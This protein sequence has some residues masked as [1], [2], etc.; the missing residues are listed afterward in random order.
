MKSPGAMG[1]R[2]LMRHSSSWHNSS[3]SSHLWEQAPL[4][5]FLTCIIFWLVVPNP[6]RGI[7]FPNKEKVVALPR[8]RFFVAAP[9]NSEQC[10]HRHR[11]RKIRRW[12]STPATG[13]CLE[14]PEIM[15]THRSSP[16][17]WPTLW[18]MWHQPTN[19][20]CIGSVRQTFVPS[21]R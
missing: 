4:L 15:T 8:G 10:L 5:W 6:E 1:T 7:L 19:N 20:M 9:A 17:R 16:R 12:K 11:R 18:I 2:S 14:D 13:R 3:S 21:S